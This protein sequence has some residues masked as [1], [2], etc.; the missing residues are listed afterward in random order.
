MLPSPLARLPDS[1]RRPPSPLYGARWPLASALA[2]AFA[3][4][5]LI[6]EAA[7]VG[8][9]TIRRG[10]CLRDTRAAFLPDLPPPDS[11]RRAAFGLWRGALALAVGRWLRV[12]RR[13]LIH[14]GGRLRGRCLRRLRLRPMP[15]RWRLRFKKTHQYVVGDSAPFRI[16]RD[17]RTMQ[18]VFYGDFVPMGYV[19][20]VPLWGWCD[21]TMYLHCRG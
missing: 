15:R 21:K 12:G 8:L 9:C 10:R 20:I 5:F 13:C 3:L 6:Q 1:F 2:V 18:I 17:F 11:F 4:A 7:A 14:S 19:C 16:E